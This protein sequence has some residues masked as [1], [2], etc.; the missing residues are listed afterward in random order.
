M[1]IKILGYEITLTKERDSLSTQGANAKIEKS[2]ESI[3]KALDEI[4]N[5]GLKYSEYRVQK[6]SGI[7]INTI[8]KYRTEID[9]YRS[10]ISRSLL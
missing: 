2:L 7:S 9:S 4:E 1:K 8:K 3:K 5:K 10:E 6:L